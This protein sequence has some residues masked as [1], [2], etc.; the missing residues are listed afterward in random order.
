MSTINLL[1]WRDDYRQEKKREFFSILVLASIFACIVGFLWHTHIASEI[2]VQKKRNNLLEAEIAQLQSKVKEIGQLRKR[3][4][5]LEARIT[6]IQDL[7]FNRPLAVRYFEEFVRAVPEGLY[8]SKLDR[9]GDRFSV[10]GTTES[11]SRVSTLMRNLDRSDWFETPNLKTV[12]A[13]K[14]NLS[15]DA[16]AQINEANE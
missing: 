11:N 12:I 15:V 5:Q 7:Q 4:E 16:T 6:I 10:Q 8:F 13:D 1:P 14:F 2:D 9:K 3:R